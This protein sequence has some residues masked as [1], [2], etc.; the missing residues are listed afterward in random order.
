MDV[1]SF[2]MLMAAWQSEL[3]LPDREPKVLL[4]PAP[5]ASKVKTRGIFLPIRHVHVSPGSVSMQCGKVADEWHPFGWGRVEKACDDTCSF[6]T[7][8][9]EA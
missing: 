3:H 6:P 9:G 8:F 1:S 2:Y 7:R 4:A 5:S